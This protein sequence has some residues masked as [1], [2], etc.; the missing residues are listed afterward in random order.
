MKMFF[1]KIIFFVFLLSCSS[2]EKTDETTPSGLL[3]SARTKARRGYFIEAEE[4]VRKIQHQF[5]YSKENAASALLQA[6]IFFDQ[7]EWD[8]AGGAYLRFAELYPYHKKAQYAYY[9]RALSLSKKVPQKSA[10]DLSEAAPAIKACSEFLKKYPKS[11][12]ASEVKKIR[13]TI[14]KQLL[15]KEL[16][17]ARFY[18]RKSKPALHRL[19]PLIEGNTPLK[20]EAL[21]LAAQAL[22]KEENKAFEKRFAKE[23][24]KFR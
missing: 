13:S 17:I 12:H 6:D 11:K 19:S 3:K 5:P 15:E 14:K 21:K 7:R 22:K 23:L 8:E 4:K 16:E 1:L 2:L 18:I 24:E 9:R 10:R 20:E